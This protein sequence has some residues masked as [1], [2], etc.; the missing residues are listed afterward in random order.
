[1]GILAWVVSHASVEPVIGIILD[2]KA[3]TPYS[4]RH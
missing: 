1:M 4:S 3:Q 2:R